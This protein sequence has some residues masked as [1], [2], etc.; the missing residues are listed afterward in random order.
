MT[1]GESLYLVIPALK[2]RLVFGFIVARSKLNMEELTL[3]HTAS[4]RSRQPLR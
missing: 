3:G 4:T 1:E 2:N